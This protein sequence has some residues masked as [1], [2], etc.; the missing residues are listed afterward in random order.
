[1]E[2]YAG[3]K[4]YIEI[5]VLQPLFSLAMNLHEEHRMNY[6]KIATQELENKALEALNNIGIEAKRQGDGV[7]HF[8]STLPPTLAES[9][10]R[11]HIPHGEIKI[12]MEGTGST[13]T[14]KVADVKH[15]NE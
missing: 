1:M 7:I 2:Y 5:T 12:Q 8:T 4:Q 6:R 13:G 3:L 15:F 10:I 9:R 11:G 14:V